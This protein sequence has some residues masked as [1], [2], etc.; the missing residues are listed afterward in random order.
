M[1]KLN[2]NPHKEEFHATKAAKQIQSWI[3]KKYPRLAA[4]TKKRMIVECLIEL[5]EEKK[6]LSAHG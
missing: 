6:F 4:S 5:T 2:Q 3:E 1:K